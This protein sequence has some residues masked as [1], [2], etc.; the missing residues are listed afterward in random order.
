MSAGSA[1]SA[2]PLL[3]A[4]AGGRLTHTTLWWMRMSS[5][6]EI[7]AEQVRGGA[8]WARAAPA[9]RRA[10]ARLAHLVGVEAV[11]FVLARLRPQF[12]QRRGAV[13]E[14]DSPHSLRPRRAGAE[15]GG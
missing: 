4:R 1:A 3:R 6:W 9:R 11:V 10:R 15:R 5:A 2:A 8:W 13:R 14:E 12:A 7:W